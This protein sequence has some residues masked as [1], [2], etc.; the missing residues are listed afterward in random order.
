MISGG[1]FQSTLPVRGGTIDACSLV[2][3]ITRFQSTLP[4]RGGTFSRVIL[5]PC[6]TDF[7]PPSPCGEGRQNLSC[8]VDVSFD[9]NPPSPCGE[10]PNLFQQLQEQG[11]I[12]IHPPRA[13]RDDLC[14]SFADREQISIHP[15]RAG[16]DSGG[17]CTDCRRR[18]FNPPSPCGEG[19][20]KYTK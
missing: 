17:A 16:R 4:V 9:F 3:T 1:K 8:I 14:L 15:P 5:S 7:N 10:G 6:L 19:Q 12:S 20:Q 13:G 2:S 18:Y 11:K